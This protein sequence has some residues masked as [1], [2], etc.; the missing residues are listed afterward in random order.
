ME[1]IS[2]LSELNATPIPKANAK[3]QPTAQGKP[4]IH[5]Q[6]LFVT[7][8]KQIV[9]AAA[10]NNRYVQKQVNIIKLK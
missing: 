4:Q 10:N 5:K 3:P 7:K 8:Y 6:L 9:Y 2:I 1:A